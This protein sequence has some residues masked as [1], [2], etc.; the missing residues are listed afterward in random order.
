MTPV[1][2]EL[3]DDPEATE[4]LGEWLGRHL[5][6]GDTLALV[7][8]LGA[9]KTTLVRGLAFGL[10]LDD[11]EAVSSPTYLLVLEHPGPKPLL[12]AD[13]YLPAKLQGFLEDGGLEYLLGGTAV[14]AVEW[15]DQVR[16]L[17]PDNTLWLTVEITEDRGRRVELRPPATGGYAFV[18]DGP[19]IL[20]EILDR[21]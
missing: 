7:G 3:P 16:D 20:A 1:T 13:A 9:G 6:P 8:D 21:D 19:K 14:V 11:P 12:H 15:A 17:L 18:S 10:E 5:Q 2:L 4:R